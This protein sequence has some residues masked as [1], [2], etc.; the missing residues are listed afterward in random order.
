MRVGSD[1]D[2]VKKFLNSI[3][4]VA[5]VR[6]TLAQPKYTDDWREGSKYRPSQK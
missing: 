4:R 3:K 2:T 5:I 1:D 6:C